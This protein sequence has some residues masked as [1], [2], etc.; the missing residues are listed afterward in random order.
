MCNCSILCFIALIMLCRHLQYA[1]FN[2]SHGIVLPLLLFTVL[3]EFGHLFL[4]LKKRDGG[5][6]GWSLPTKDRN[7]WRIRNN[8]GVLELG[9]PS[10]WLDID[11]GEQKITPQTEHNH[12]ACRQS[13]SPFSWTLLSFSSHPAASASFLLP[14]LLRDRKQGYIIQLF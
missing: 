3:N 10:Y 6:L 7:H 1:P 12:L 14:V 2:L 13:L 5:K 4:H 8:A 11:L 9:C